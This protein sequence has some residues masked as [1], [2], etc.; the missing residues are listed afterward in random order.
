MFVN[1]RCFPDQEIFNRH[2]TD[3]CVLSGQGSLAASIASDTFF[4][5]TCP[6]LRNSELKENVE[7]P[8]PNK[9][10]VVEFMSIQLVNT[11]YPTL[12]ECTIRTAML[13]LEYY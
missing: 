8:T 11:M 3:I 10:F 2:L 6:Q 9:D 12:L 5:L 1:S 13:M 4:S 7:F